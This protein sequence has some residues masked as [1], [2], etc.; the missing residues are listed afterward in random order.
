MSAARFERLRSANDDFQLLEALKS[1]RNRRHRRRE[2]LIE[3]VRPIN[4]ALAHGWAVRA[5]VHAE[6]RP[7]SRWAEGIVANS[8][9]RVR[10][11]LAAG[12]FDRLSDR[13]EPSELLAVVAMADDD[14]GRIPVHDGM[15]VVVLDRPTSPGNLGSLVRSAD[16]LGADAVM[17]TGHAADPWGP[18]AVRASTGSVFAL[19]VLSVESHREVAAWL[20]GVRERLGKVLLAGSDEEGDAAVS[21]VDL[22]GPTVLALGN[23]A[24]GLSRTMRE[25]CDVVVRIPMGGA[26]TSL[27]LACAGSILL[28]ELDRQRRSGTQ[29]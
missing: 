23:E 29:P 9:A 5:L 11:E 24:A 20:N 26:A 7:L 13:E 12:L 4:L 15:V 25:L 18:Q 16:A 22:R 2:L 21:N 19:P 28:Y 3:G 1:N 8:T 14:L 27:N 17:I 6:G 10:Y